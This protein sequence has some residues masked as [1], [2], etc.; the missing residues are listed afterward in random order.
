MIHRLSVSV[1][2]NTAYTKIVPTSNETGTEIQRMPVRIDRFLAAPAIRK[3]STQ[4][5]PQ[6]SIVWQGVQRGLETI[7]SLVILAWQVK[8]DAETNL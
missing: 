3:S 7:N 8:Q 4:S 1:Q 2:I 6:Q 5:V